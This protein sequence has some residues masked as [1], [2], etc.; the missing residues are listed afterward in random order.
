M[1]WHAHQKLECGGERNQVREEVSFNRLT[2]TFLCCCLP[3]V[4]SL[5]L[6]F[7][8]SAVAMKVIWSV[9]S[10]MQLMRWLIIYMTVYSLRSSIRSPFPIPSLLEKQ[11]ENQKSTMYLFGS[12]APFTSSQSKFCCSNKIKPLYF[13]KWLTFP[14]SF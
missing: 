14:V 2:E 9:W 6:S 11:A 10:F 12:F 8:L 5:R 4:S 7:V 3:L 13:E 1:A